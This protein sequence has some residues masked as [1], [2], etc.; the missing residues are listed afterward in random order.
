[1]TEDERETP[2]PPEPITRDHRRTIYLVA[3]ID[4]AMADMAA[5]GVDARSQQAVWARHL[6]FAWDDGARRQ[7]DLETALAVLR[8]HVEALQ[9]DREV[10]VKTIAAMATEIA[11][12]RAELEEFKRR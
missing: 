6:G 3:A 1:V 5:H 2:E 8:S 7:T 12:L 10:M 11:A 4:P 9:K